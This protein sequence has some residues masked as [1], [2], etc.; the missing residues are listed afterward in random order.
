MFQAHFSHGS[1]RE[2]R[3]FAADISKQI[4]DLPQANV[5]V[6]LFNDTSIQ[7]TTDQAISILHDELPQALYAGCS[8]SGNICDGA[9]VKGELPNITATVNVFEDPLTQI[10]VHQLPL[11]REHRE[12][13]AEDIR[14]LI[15]DRPWVKAVEM[16]TTLI[17]VGMADFCDEAR[18]LPEHI[19]IFGG[20]ALTSETINMWEG[21]PYVFSSAGKSSGES[22]VLVL[23]GGENFHLQTLTI[24]GWKPLGRPMTITR[25][26]GPV[27]Y[28]LDG[29][30]AYDRYRHYLS[31]DDGDQFSEGSI[32]F[33][34]AIDHDD[35]TVIKALVGIGKDGSITLSSDLASYH[36]NCRIAYGDPGTI[37]RSIRE[38][39]MRIQ[40]FDP[41][42]I[43]AYSCAARRKYWGDEMISRETLPLQSIA[44]TA[45]FYTGGE[46]SREGGELLHHNVTLVVVSFREGETSGKTACE[47]YVD[48]T[49]FTRQMEIVNSLATFVGVTSAELEDAYTQLK[50]AAKTDGLTGLFNRGEIESR[51]E[52]TLDAGARGADGALPSVV[53]LDIDNF[54]AVNDTYG[55]KAGDEV[56]REFGNLLQSLVDDMD[57][58][59]SGRWGGEEFMVLLPST[60]LAEAHDFA[61]RARREFAALSFPAS[62]S[63]TVSIGVAQALPEETSDLLCQRVD[64][65]LYSAKKNGKNRVET[66]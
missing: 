62:G 53:M 40:E 54:K 21:L 22:I 33:P 65:A 23:Y 13:T 18:L 38:G 6:R 58:A 45:G 34:L 11:N 2:F 44:P 27:L 66:A 9:L 55:H 15:N 25:A 20:G 52:A 35:R 3:R 48:E 5:L 7:S 32:L 61:E 8:T 39:I 1:E 64:K 4:A 49:E 43:M 16:L 59:T 57:E 12:K 24:Y 41:Q 56:L 31:L 47:I 46:F 17:D 14:Q 19:V 42:G 37:L 10:E 36:K 51:I 60:P 63:H 28:E 29:V 50:I 26:K 30:P